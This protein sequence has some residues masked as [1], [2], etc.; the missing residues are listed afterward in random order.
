[1][2]ARVPQ[3]IQQLLAKPYMRGASFS[4]LIK[5]TESGRVV[6]AYDTLRQLTPASVM[7]LVTTATTLELMGEDYRYP[8]RITYDGHIEDGTLCG[9]LYIEGSG[10][11][12]L[13]SAFIDEEP[14]AFARDWI[15]AI[16]R[17]GIRR[18]TGSV[19]ADASLFDTEGLSLKWA[20]EDL[21]SYYGTGSYGLSVFDNRYTLLLRTGAP[22][23]RP[24]VTGTEPALP[25]LRFHNY[26]TARS[27]AIDS[28]Y[29][30][31]AP[32]SDERYLYGVVPAN[33][34]RYTMRG[35]IPDP[36]LFL[37][38]YLTRPSR[39]PGIEVEG[40]P[41]SLRLA[42]EA[43]ETPAGERPALV[44]TYS[45]PL[46]TLAGVTNRVSHNLFADALLKT[47]GLGYEP[48]AGETLSTFERGIRRLRAH[49]EE[50]GLDLSTLWMYDGSG[51]AMADKLSASFLTELLLYMDRESVRGEAFRGSLPRAGMEGSVRNFLKGSALAGKVRLKSG[52]MSRV[53]SY[54][55][56]IDLD[57]K[58][59]T[60]VVLAN[61]YA[62]DGRAMSYAIERLLLAIFAT[63]T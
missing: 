25:D 57:G 50:R 51:L 12:S 41:T 53:K 33:R 60:V 22:G 31:G 49:W 58:R 5:E 32:L 42:R 21:G 55:G 39:E 11:P 13:G 2:A 26:L 52:S 7:K 62:C 47:I 45:P 29:I 48:R 8:T 4:L 23:S 27:I 10:D 30:L 9:N 20:R 16:R 15:E 56:Y 19:V 36:P 38:Q 14:E 3:P 1:M 17:T 61:H 43:S 59:Y 44:I 46:S 40:K 54:A 34:A 24:Q 28:A 37:A 6:C 35:D 18:V 63:L